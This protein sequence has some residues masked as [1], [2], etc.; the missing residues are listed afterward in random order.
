[1]TATAL[2]PSAFAAPSSRWLR[3]CNF[4]YW[5][6]LSIPLIGCGAAMLALTNPA[7]YPGL[8]LINIW[9][10]GYHHVIST[11][12]RIG[13][14][15]EAVQKHRFLLTQLPWLVLAVTFA[16][17]YAAG[18]WLVVS[19]YFYWQWFHYT[20]QSYGI[21]RVYLAKC[22]KTDARYGW[23]NT[24]AIYMVP[25][26]GLLNRFGSGADTFLGMELFT[27]TLP[28]WVLPAAGTVAAALV[29]AQ[30]LLWRTWH[31]QG[32]LPGQYVTYVLSH[33]AVFFVAYL[34]IPHADTGWMAVN[35]WHNLQYISFVWHAN[36]MAYQ[37]KNDSGFMARLSQRDRVRHY[38]AFCI[39]LTLLFYGSI[40]L[41]GE[42]VQPHT[43]IPVALMIFMAI[44]F[45]HY[46]VDGTIWKRKRKPV[47]VTA[48]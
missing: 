36:N 18:A 46:I 45:H 5:F 1:M 44:N 41:L 23:V 9:L 15:R 43:A 39:G 20:R 8:M 22:G 7:L 29:L 19:I 24:A 3:S 11:F 42:A 27:V 33:H 10:L 2:S 6:I 30:L 4:D 38:F 17:A 21:S 37:G 13:F 25:V 48:P 35:I 47:G 32:D 31:K 16:L 40:R 28:G 26:A 12:T 14:T 34:L